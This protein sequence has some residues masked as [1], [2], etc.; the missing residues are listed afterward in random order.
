MTH[1]RRLLTRLEGEIATAPDAARADRL[2]AERI[3]YLA[4]YG[5]LDDA[6]AELAWL[7]SRY[8]LAPHPI[9]SPW[10]IFADALVD[11]AA[12]QHDS[13]L[14]KMR[15]AHALSRAG[16]IPILRSLAAAWLAHI[17]WNLQDLGPTIEYAQ[18][19]LEHAVK[20]H[21]A[22]TI[23]VSLVLGEGLLISRREDLGQTWYV[24]S[25]ALAQQIGDEPS[26]SA[27]VFNLTSVRLMLM[28]QDILSNQ[29]S[30][31][32]VP[33]DPQISQNFDQAMGIGMDAQT[34]IQQA[35]VFSLQGDVARA[36]DLYE[37]QIG[38]TNLLAGKR[39]RSEWLSDQAWCLARLGRPIEAL[40]SAKTAEAAIVME[41]QTDDLAAIHSRLSRTYALVGMG[42]EST[43]HQ[44]IADEFWAK[45][46]VFQL[47]TATLFARLSSP[48]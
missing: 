14:M 24:K 27:L 26:L 10:I 19:A 40:R 16:D 41:T 46:S 47:E 22:A 31:M 39:E 9:V 38:E 33:I 4:G 2:R 23:R 5:R 28:R 30:P 21:H 13:S 8:E 17:Y 36:L 11:R 48:H 12:A 15:R 42:T 32:P 1:S 43:H 29:D 20:D 18:E 6:R 35:R 44:R 45:Y 7:R 3:G 34:P 37:H 25:R